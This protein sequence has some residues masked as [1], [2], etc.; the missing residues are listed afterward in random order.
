[1]IEQTQFPFGGGESNTTNN[2][3]IISIIIISILVGATIYYG[4][5][6]FPIVKKNKKQEK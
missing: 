2:G 5:Q 1:M 3:K 4:Y 6:I